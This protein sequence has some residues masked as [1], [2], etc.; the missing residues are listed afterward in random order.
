[1]LFASVACDDQQRDLVQSTGPH[2][3]TALVVN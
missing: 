1:M 3:I 2:E